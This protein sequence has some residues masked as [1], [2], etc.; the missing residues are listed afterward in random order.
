VTQRNDDDD[1]D[2]DGED[3]MKIMAGQEKRG[4][5]ESVIPNIEEYWIFPQFLLGFSLH[6]S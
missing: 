6:Y 1:D 2:D 3:P 4:W 5:R